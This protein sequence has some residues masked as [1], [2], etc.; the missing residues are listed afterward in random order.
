ML[1]TGR[2]EIATLIEHRAREVGLSRADI[3]GR[4]GYRNF[5]K[6]IRR[7][8]AICAGELDDSPDLLARLPDALEVAPSLVREAIAHTREQVRQLQRQAASERD[9]AWRAAFEP[10]AP[11]F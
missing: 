6:G 1:M 4:L 2:F 9:R 11:S 8:D 7:I 10:H 5:V 3:A